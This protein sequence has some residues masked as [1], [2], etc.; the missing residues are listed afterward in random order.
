MQVYGLSVHRYRHEARARV[1]Q[2]LHFVDQL[3]GNLRANSRSERR[4]HDEWNVR[5]HVL[6]RRMSIVT[7][8]V[9]HT[10]EF[11]SGRRG[12]WRNYLR[13]SDSDAT[14]ASKLNEDGSRNSV[15]SLQLCCV[16]ADELFA[17]GAGGRAAAFGGN[18][19]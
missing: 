10:S 5:L 7:A 9:Y 14:A 19:A 13:H 8:R 15:L 4:W 12:S 6:G 3:D 1:H 2:F 11:V 18:A 17:N 16:R